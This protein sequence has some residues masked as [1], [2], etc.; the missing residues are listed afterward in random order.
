MD[1]EASPREPLDVLHHEWPDVPGEAA[2]AW[3]P[4][5]TMTAED[6]ALSGASAEGPL[7][8]AKQ[9]GPLVEV[10]VHVAHRWPTTNMYG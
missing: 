4:A 3:E 8:L 1:D 9:T 7:A 10:R 6:A 5:G 2:G